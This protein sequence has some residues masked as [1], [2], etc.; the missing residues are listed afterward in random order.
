M[1]ESPSQPM[2][3][4]S[5]PGNALGMN[6]LISHSFGSSKYNRVAITKKLHKQT[7]PGVVQRPGAPEA[8]ISSVAFPEE[9]RSRSTVGS[10]GS[11]IDGSFRSGGVGGGTDEA[12]FEGVGWKCR[13]GRNE[14][15]T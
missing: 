4:P 10:S 13:V 15:G 14:K 8:G 2:E 6:K 3:M 7:F 9:R 5:T 12:N 1:K 11:Q